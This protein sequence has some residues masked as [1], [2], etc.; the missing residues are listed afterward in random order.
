MT[1][2]EAADRLD[3][4]DPAVQQAVLAQLNGFLGELPSRMGIRYVEVGPGRLVATM[5]VEGNRQPLGL[6]HGGASCV[7]AETVGSTAAALHGQRR[8]RVSVGVDINATHHR[9]ARS[10]T[11]TAVCTPLYEGG[12]VTT[13]SIAITDDEGRL[14]CSARM[15]CQL[16][17]TSGSYL[18]DPRS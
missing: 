2:T 17:T 4:S 1:S 11:V 14:V 3:L 12:S 16:I 13:H 18:P 6:L 8:G 9:A 10:G 7:L 5:P 15:T